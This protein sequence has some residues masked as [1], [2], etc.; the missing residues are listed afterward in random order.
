MDTI[1]VLGLVAG[2]LC[3]ASFLPQVIKIRKSK[4]AKDISLGMF[5][6]FCIGVSLWAVC[7][8][9]VKSIPIIVA[10]SATLFLSAL[11]LA[12]KIKYK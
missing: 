1:N 11:I 5:V 10:N 2:A 6:V 7:G 3:T 12:M 4:S 8:I 9:M